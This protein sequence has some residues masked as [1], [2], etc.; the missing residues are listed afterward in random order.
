MGTEQ[1]KTQAKTTYDWPEVLYEC[2][3]AVEVLTKKKEKIGWASLAKYL[4]MATSTLR[5]GFKT[6]FSL[7]LNDL[8]N[9]TQHAIVK[10]VKELRE[11]AITFVDKVEGKEVHWREYLELAKTDQQLRKVTDTSQRMA[12]INIDTDK[13]FCL[14]FTGDWQLGDQYVDYDSWACDMEFVLST[15]NLG[16][17]DLGDDRQNMRSFKIL[18][19]VLG[20]VLSPKQQALMLRSVVKDLTSRNKLIAKVGGNHDE[21]FDE[22]I[23]GDA[24]Q[25]FLLENLKAPRFRNRGLLKLNVGDQLYTALI[26]HKSRFKSFLRATHGAMREHQLS[27]P[28]DIIAGGHDHQPGA[29]HYFHYQLARDAEMGFGGETYL[30][31]TGTYQDSIYGWK[32][33]HNGGFPVNYTIVLFPDRYKMVL[34]DNP[35]DAVRFANS[36]ND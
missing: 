9:L 11:A 4:G 30:I 27:Y 21:E 18:S 13:P 20:Q 12:T 36:F 25:S 29:E 7:G 33:F 15:P 22:R 17:I 2:S 6:Q 5:E 35:R 23:F 24:L 26:F 10:Q 19:L 14:M 8:P 1:A 34:F 31:K 3:I 32:Y 16:M 28:A